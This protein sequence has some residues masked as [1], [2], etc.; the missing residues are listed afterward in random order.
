M[1]KRAHGNEATRTQRQLRVG[2]EIRHALTAVM[3]EA[4]FRD[5]DLQGVNVTITEVQVS[6][7]LKNATTFVMTLGGEDLV[8]TLSALKRAGPF[9]R[10]ELAHRIQLRYAPSLKFEA[11]TTFDYAEKIE[12]ALHRPEVARDLEAEDESDEAQ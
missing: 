10:S 1:S 8:K 4:H 12:R 2:E 6:P 5:P 3:R 11:D 7:D 9:L